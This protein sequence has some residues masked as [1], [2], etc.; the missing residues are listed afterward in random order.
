MQVKLALTWKIFV[1]FLCELTLTL[2]KFL[3]SV[4]ADMREAVV[5]SGQMLDA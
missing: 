4:I 3:S 1:L 5:F 2:H